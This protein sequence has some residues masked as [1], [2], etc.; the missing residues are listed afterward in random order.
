MNAR[1]K[2]K[3]FTFSN[4]EMTRP[5]FRMIG[6]LLS[7]HLLIIDSNEPFGDLKP[8]FYDN[9]LLYLA[10]DLAS[11]LL[12]AFDGTHTGIP[13]P[14]VSLYVRPTFKLTDHLP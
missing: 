11:R 3:F 14:R 2:L 12:P 6:G 9:E 7:A 10:H 13:Y 1:F 8:D 4:K 5:C